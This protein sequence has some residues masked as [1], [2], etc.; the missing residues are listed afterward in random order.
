MASKLSI[1]QGKYAT[2]DGRSALIRFVIASIA[3]YSLAVPL[4]K[5]ILKAISKLE[6]AFLWAA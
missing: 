5:G 4:P 3:L 1:G 6:R 2:T